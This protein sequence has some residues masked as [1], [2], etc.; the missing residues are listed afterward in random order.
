MKLPRG[1]FK[2][3]RSYV[4]RIRRGG[5][6]R[7]VSHGTDRG[8]AIVRHHE[9]MAAGTVPLGRMTVADAARRWL[10]TYV[11]TA[12][13]AKNRRDATT[14]VRKY[15]GAFMGGKL[16]SRLTGDDFREYCLWLRGQDL[17]PRTITHVLSDARCLCRWAE[18]E[19]YVLKSPFPRRVMPRVQERPPDRLNENEVP[20]LA[21]LPDPWGFVIRFGLGTGLRWAEMCRAQRSHLEGDVLVVSHTKN[22][23]I[24]RVPITGDLL[25][26][27]RSRVG[28]LIPF[29]ENSPGAFNRTIRRQT[30][31]E[32]FHVHQLRHTFGCRWVDAGGNLGHLQEILGH[33]SIVTTQRYARLTDEGVRSEALRVAQAVQR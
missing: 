5:M 11:A 28:K 32:R 24:R 29:S 1:L 26:E 9:L 33:R 12:R 27:L 23:R 6:D 4:S 14:R 16:L 21:T 31:L 30:G 17:K 18:S 7:W 22:G 8:L 15:L 3:G 19:N 20:I 13:N 25:K 2:R 10:E